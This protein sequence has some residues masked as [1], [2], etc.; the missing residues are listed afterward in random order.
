MMEVR[1]VSR[2]V[3]VS[4]TK[5]RR[6]AGMILNKTYEDAIDILTYVPSPNAALIKKVLESA[7]ANA[8][9]NHE[10]T[11]DSLFVANAIVDVGPTWKRFRAGSMGRAMRRRRRTSHIKIVLTDKLEKTKKK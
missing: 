8:E 7:G 1:A 3:R 5:M 11:K 9:E 2:Y 6:I 4:P 10:L